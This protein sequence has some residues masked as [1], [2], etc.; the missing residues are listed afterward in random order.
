MSTTREPTIHESSIHISVMPREVGEYLKID[1]PQVLLDCTLGGGG[2][3]ALMLEANPA[4]TVLA[5]DRDKHAIR[6]CREKLSRFGSRLRIEHGSF[7]DLSEICGAQRFTGVLAD[8]GVSTD[9]LKEG[10]GFSF[11]DE[12]PL[13][14]R[15]D[16]SQE[17]NAATVVN[18]Y[19]ERDLFE[20]LKRGGVGPEARAIAKAV[21]QDRPLAS[22]KAL[23]ELIDRVVPEK[24]KKPRFHAATV[25]FQAIRIEVNQE[26][27][28][29]EALLSQAPDLIEPHG[30]LAVIA[31]HSGE[32]RVVTQT[33][34]RWEQGEQLPALWRGNRAAP[35]A[36]VPGAT[37]KRSDRIAAGERVGKVLTRKAV[38]PEGEEVD[39][40][41]NAR[42][43]RLRVFEF[44]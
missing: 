23:A 30:R 7:A 43:S 29:I 21:V 1:A 26:F 38:V 35:K 6:R 19:P 9:Q 5:I 4:S 40:N 34:R 22:T 10:R 12:G 18:E 37:L 20:V 17:I 31:F 42:S 16:P 25:P 14:M 27:S 11:H 32:D 28:Q 3:T 36:L 41:S 15:M 13:D 44:D 8:L 39:S 2:H 33:M 24:F